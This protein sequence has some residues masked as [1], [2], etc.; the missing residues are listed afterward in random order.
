MISYVSEAIWHV[1]DLRI[2]D[3]VYYTIDKLAVMINNNTGTI[4]DIRINTKASDQV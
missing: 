3:I 2:I 4:R 1:D